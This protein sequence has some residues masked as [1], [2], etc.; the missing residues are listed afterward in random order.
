MATEVEVVHRH[1]RHQE[2]DRASWFELPFFLELSFW[3]FVG[4]FFFTEPGFHLGHL[5]PAG[6]SSFPGECRPYFLSKGTML[7]TCGEW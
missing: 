2:A 3:D 6:A 1:R 7:S 5:L 4:F